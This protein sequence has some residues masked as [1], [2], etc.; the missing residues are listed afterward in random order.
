MELIVTHDIIDS[1]REELFAGLRSYNQRF[2]NPASFGQIGIF[3][4]NSAGTMTGGLIA[5]RKG[6]WLCIDYLWVGEESRGLK[7]GSALVKEAEQEAMRLGCRHALVDTFSF[8]ALPFY[9]KQ[10]YQLQMSLPDFPEEG[11]LRHYLIK[12]NMQAA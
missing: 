11:M 8:Q 3:H 10:G 12:K 2:I 9:E 4:R 7:L 6:L 5:M 1:D